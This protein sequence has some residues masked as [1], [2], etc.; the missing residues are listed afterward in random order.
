MT[1]AVT[2]TSS[3]YTIIQ[4]HLDVPQI[5]IPSGNCHQLWSDINLHN[6]SELIQIFFYQYIT[7]LFLKSIGGTFCIKDKFNIFKRMLIDN[8]FI[9]EEIKEEMLDL[10][11]KIQKTYYGF[12]RFVYIYK[13]KKSQYV[14]KND[15]YLNE[16]DE[17]K[18][19]VYTLYQDKSKY[20]FMIN[21]LIN[22]INNNLSNSP[23]FFVSPKISKNPYNNMPLTPASLYNIYFFI[24]NR[25]G[26][27]P[28]LFHYFF[29][30]NFN[31]SLFAQKYECIIRNT[32]IK[33]FVNVS[34]IKILYPNIQHML[35]VYAKKIRIH[36]EFPK[37]KLLNI[38]RPYLQLYYLEKFAISGSG[39]KYESK[40]ELEDKMR[41]FVKF[42]PQF[43]RKYIHFLSKP[44]FIFQN[45]DANLNNKRKR[46]PSITT[47]NNKHISF[48]ETLEELNIINQSNR[49]YNFNEI[50]NLVLYPVEIQRFNRYYVSYNEG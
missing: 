48:N 24:K 11:C 28:E 21:D 15:L 34:S 19:N 5:L 1:T 30:C 10:F 20:L 9:S 6:I 33:N 36:K 32:A 45:D 49:Q 39:I 18:I 40:T 12:S 4:K 27:I 35:R 38:M 42:N 16:I 3:F 13:Y 47:F 44:I 43:G 41:L 17:S 29:M 7:S 26:I 23:N 37:E 14:I 2:E 22:I 31:I 25:N 46:F 50:L 8:V